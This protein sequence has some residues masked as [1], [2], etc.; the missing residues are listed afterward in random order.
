MTQDM[1]GHIQDILSVEGGDWLPSYLHIIV[2]VIVG[3]T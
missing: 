3:D 1:L 2:K